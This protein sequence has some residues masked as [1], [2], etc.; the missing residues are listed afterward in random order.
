MLR[1]RIQVSEFWR[2]NWKQHSRSPIVQGNPALAAYWRRIEAA[3]SPYEKTSWNKWV[4][5]YA[6]LET[7]RLIGFAPATGFKHF[8]KNVGTW[9]QLGF[10]NAASH[11]P[12]AYGISFRNWL[13]SPEVQKGF[14]VKALKKL[15]FNPKVERK[16]LDEYARAYTHQYRIMNHMSDMEFGPVDP[17]LGNA[18]DRWLYAATDK[19]A[20]FIKG[21]EAFDRA[22]SFSAALDMAAKRGMT[23][24]QATYGI[25]DTILKNNFL[26]GGLN[27]LWMKNPTI[28]SL[29]L[30]QN[31]PFK[32]MERR[33]VTAMRAKNDL[34]TVWGVIKKQDLRQNLE[35]M[36]G[37]KNYIRGGEQE[38][39]KNLIADALFKDR[40]V[41]GT[42]ITQQFMREFLYGGLVVI[43]LGSVLD[44]D[45]MPHTFH[46]PFLSTFGGDKP[47][48][49]TSPFTSAAYKAVHDAGKRDEDT[50]LPEF[51][52][53]E[54]L[55][56]WLWKDQQY[57]PATAR[58]LMKISDQDIPA[59][60]KDSKLK[61]FF[62]VPSKS[63]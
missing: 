60:Y 2:S 11:M 63:Q 50:S 45:F 57:I 30:F 47:Q 41:F 14:A 5:R 49:A 13:N 62:S 35:D 42:P 12:E 15:G 48:L 52:F 58:K 6:M 28:R 31:T 18:F 56:N 43:G 7:M 27:P 34:K 55:N 21:V 51:L 37:L 25:Y 59:A 3:Y 38:L 10:R 26:G 53:T 54:F 16:V 23:A 24:K 39:K 33:L 9:G 4:N 19:T 22:H 61:Y 1:R 36:R 46:V 17:G 32:L 40:D 20:M 29:F 8:F 44:A